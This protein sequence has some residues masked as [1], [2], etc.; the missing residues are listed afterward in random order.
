[1]EVRSEKH[2]SL[3]AY[4]KL[5]NGMKRTGQYAIVEHTILLGIGISI[6]LG[7]M[8]GFQSLG[9]NVQGGA[10]ESEAELLSLF[11]ASNSIELVESGAE[12]KFTV[13]LPASVAKQSYAVRL[14]DAGVEVISAGTR[15]TASLYGLPERLDLSGFVVSSDR[16]MSL[17][18]ANNAVT[19]TTEQ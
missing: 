9:T 8:A 17:I 19:L 4:R 15:N 6:A 14:T 2:R 1:M 13:A 11:V 16:F 18:H 12:G 3:S 7:F 5:V 10:A